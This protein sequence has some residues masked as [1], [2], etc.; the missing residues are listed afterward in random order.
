MVYVET[1]E[2]LKA[3]VERKEQEIVV[4]GKLATKLKGLAKLKKISQK[5]RVALLALLAGSGATAVAAVAAAPVTGGMSVVAGKLALAVA[6]PA[7]GVPVSAAV[8]II[9][10]IGII[11]LT[12]ISLLR[13]YNIDMNFGEGKN[14]KFTKNKDT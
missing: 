6:A 11:G 9:G 5:Q 4:G 8:A 14:I 2:E 10:V 13:D 1:K 12:A 3:A 7:E